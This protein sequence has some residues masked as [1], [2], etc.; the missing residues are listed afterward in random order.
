M[1]R[2]HFV[3]SNGALSNFRAPDDVKPSWTASLVG[4]RVTADLRANRVVVAWRYRRLVLAADTIDDARFWA[5]A[6]TAA[7]DNASAAARRAACAAGPMGAIA[8]GPGGVVGVGAMNY[9]ATGG[10]GVGG[11]NGGHDS[12]HVGATGSIPVNGTG[13]SGYVPVAAGA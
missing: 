2:R 13:S 4:A 3:L 8:R 9:N 12:A 5:Q 10:G 1:V 11:V 6:L 7:A